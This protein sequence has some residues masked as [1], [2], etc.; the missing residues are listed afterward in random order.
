MSHDATKVVVRQNRVYCS[1]CATGYSCI[2]NGKG[3]FRIPTREENSVV[4]FIWLHCI[5]ASAC[6][7]RSQ[8]LC[9]MWQPMLRKLFSDHIFNEIF[10]NVCVLWIFVFCLCFLCISSTSCMNRWLN[11]VVVGRPKLI[12]QKSAH[13]KCT[14]INRRPSC[15][16]THTYTP[17]QAYGTNNCV[18]S[19]RLV[20]VSASLFD[21]QSERKRKLF[22]FY[23]QR[24]VCIQF[25]RVVIDARS[26]CGYF[27]L[28]C[29]SLVFFAIHLKW[30]QC[31]VMKI[32][33]FFF[34]FFFCVYTNFD[35]K[36]EFFQLV[37]K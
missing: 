23:K 9:K 22:S 32:N 35:W 2:G 14:H 26:C 19:M 8:S 7:C 20:W 30:T 16:H 24:S 6:T 10:V 27:S 15:T 17:A 12:N 36:I 25:D 37:N 4:L 28:C 18:P 11:S 33:I 29:R 21:R 31:F 3:Q 13:R 34:F 5:L 1:I